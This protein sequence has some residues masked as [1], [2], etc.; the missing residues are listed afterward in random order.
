MQSNLG[1][2]RDIDFLTPGNIS[3]NENTDI[4]HSS[5]NSKKLK[6]FNHSI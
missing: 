3:L 6:I 1:I 2:K 5:D 4:V